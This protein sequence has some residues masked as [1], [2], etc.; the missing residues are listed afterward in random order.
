[1][2]GRGRP[3]STNVEGR[4]GG[5]PGRRCAALAM[6]ACLLLTASGEV[7]AQASWF[8]RVS[9]A[10]EDF[11]ER[12]TGP[13]PRRR[14]P[15][16]RRSVAPRTPGTSERPSSNAIASVP[17]PPRK[18]ARPDGETVLEPSTALGN[19]AVAGLLPPR[20]APMRSGRGG[21]SS[22]PPR[23]PPP[24]PGFRAQTAAMPL[25]VPRLCPSTA[26]RPVV[27]EEISPISAGR[28]GVARPVRVTS[29]GASGIAI[30]PGATVNCA[31]TAALA[32]WAD[33][34]VT[35]A[36][37][38]HLGRKVVSVRNRASYV[39]RSR[40]GIA[41]AKPSEH[42]A[43]N[44]IDVGEFALEG[45]GRVAVATGW[46]GGGAH[47]AFLREVHRRSCG[48]F[49]TV[50]GPKADRFHQDHFH[51]DLARRGSAYCR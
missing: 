37:R 33:T 27:Y 12:V 45:G 50:L 34:V 13:A 6:A 29:A 49:K 30:A 40:N 35:P 28:C 17:L 1:M 51:L 38:R 19:P 24:P 20:G 46:N 25:T 3:R 21:R 48:V 5:R 42:A 32:E 41:G 9:R 11:A 18:P 26:A 14:G 44:A 23:K 43:A 4:R 8:D 36:A 10:V 15:V 2:R 47:A 22:L 16:R 39:C 7:S 31:M